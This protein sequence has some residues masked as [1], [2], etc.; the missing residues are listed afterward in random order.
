MFAIA[1]PSAQ[2]LSSIMALV[3]NGVSSQHSKRAYE[4][5]IRDFLF[6]CRSSGASEFTKR[7]L[8]EYRSVLESR[9]LAAS[10]I[11]VRICAIRKLATELA[12]N[13][14]LPQDVA[15]AIG[16]VK[17]PKRKG[18]RIGNWLSASQAENLILLPDASSLKGK[19]D[20]ALLSVLLGT[21]LRRS[22]VAGLMFAHIQQRDGRWII[23]DLVG[24]HGRIRSVP[25]PR[26][27]KVAIDQWGATAHLDGGRVFRP[28]NKA[29]RITGAAWTSQSI[30]HIVKNYG[31][32]AGLHIAPHDLRRSFAKLA[33][34]GQAE[35][36]QIQLSLG[37]ESVSTT[38]LY[39][40][41]RQNLIDAPCDHLG[42]RFDKCD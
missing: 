20:R 26:W 22:E 8:Q 13:D 42:L 28:I 34:K 9:A 15:A 5:A 29:G 6:W 19:R 7:T 27:V 16:K 3:C 23:A 35:L 10:T 25:M 1:A 11:N 14:A 37:H 4:R 33:R 36:E 41:V 32:L 31:A 21:G 17:G 12:D 24:K 39:L 18:V 2:T 38:E 40:G 30:Y